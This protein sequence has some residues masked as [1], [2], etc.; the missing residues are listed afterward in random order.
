M[1][2]GIESTLTV[3]FAIQPITLCALLAPCAAADHPM[4]APAR[5]ID[6]IHCET[7]SATRIS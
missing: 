6:A 5:L 2:M 3:I 4:L 1:A 7:S